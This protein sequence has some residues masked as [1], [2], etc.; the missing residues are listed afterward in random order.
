MTLGAALAAA[1]DIDA[2]AARRGARTRAHAAARRHRRHVHAAGVHRSPRWPAARDQAEHP[3]VRRFARVVPPVARGLPRGSGVCAQRRC[4]R[5]SRSRPRRWRRWWRRAPARAASSPIRAVCPRGS[6]HCRSACCA[7]PR[8]HNARLLAMG[9]RTLGDL[10]RLPRAGFARRFGPRTARRSRSPA[11][12]ARRSAPPARAARAL[13]RARVDLDHEIEDHERIL[14]G[15][16]ALAG[17]ARAIPA[18][19]AAR[20]HRVAMPLPSL[21]RGA[22]HVRA[23]AG[24]ARGG[25]RAAAVAAARAPGHSGVARARAPLRI[26]QRRAHASARST[27]K[28]LWSP[29]ERGHAPA[30]EMPALIEHLRARLGAEAVYGIGARVRTPA[31]ECLARGGA[32]ARA[33]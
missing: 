16:A 12:A 4:S 8:T 1:P 27:S 25:C 23:A 31:R 32:R 11:R 22:D 5:I 10:L 18:R 19:A 33:R 26:A 7:G 30:D 28:P 17:R 29:G 20:H 2:A 21:P 24:C 3:S 15:A 13:S 14:A 9:V 6:N